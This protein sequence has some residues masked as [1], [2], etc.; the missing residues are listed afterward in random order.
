MLTGIVIRRSIS[1]YGFRSKNEMNN[2]GLSIS[3]LHS[4]P[5]CINEA[6][7]RERAQAPQESF[8]M[9]S[10]RPRA[11]TPAYPVQLFCAFAG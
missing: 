2:T 7:I 5:D 4:Q 6:L 11:G 1:K 8:E 10:R 3:R 9:I